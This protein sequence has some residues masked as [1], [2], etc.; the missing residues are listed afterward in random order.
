M[1]PKIIHYCWFGKRPLPVSVKRNI[2][3]LKKMFP[4]FTVMFWN[5]DN[6]NTNI[7]LW[8]SQAI[9]LRRYAFAVDYIRLYVLYKYGGIYFDTD[10]K[11]IK[12]LT[13][14]LSLKTFLC[15]QNEISGIDVG[16]VG[17]EK[18]AKWLSD[19]MEYYDKRPFVKSDNSCDFRV[20]PE[21]LEEVLKQNQYSL[22]TI[23]SL[24]NALNIESDNTIPIFTPDFF[25]PK[26]YLT[27][28]MKITDNTYCIHEFSES[29]KS[30]VERVSNKI[31]R[32]LGFKNYNILW[33]YWNLKSRIKHLVIEILNRKKTH[34][35]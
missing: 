20:M 13:P 7:N 25:C 10:V 8:V 12:S 32:F 34:A 16:T 6:F 35:K 30:S 31:S 14:L 1:I 28:K 17:S 19:C 15:W 33:S 24:N 5:D 2:N 26:N 21:I 11:V 9:K 3:L 18:G 22:V 23:N 4:N 29:W 27:G